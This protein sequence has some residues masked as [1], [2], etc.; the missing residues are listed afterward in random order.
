[1]FRIHTIETK[2]QEHPEQLRNARNGNTH[3]LLENGNGHPQEFARF[4][5]F[6]Y[7]NLV[8]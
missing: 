4:S 1:M 5:S 2:N 3:E 7:F 8:F 6:V